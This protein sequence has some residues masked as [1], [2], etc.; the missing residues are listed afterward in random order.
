MRHRISPCLTRDRG[1][2]QGEIGL[3]TKL[4]W[5]HYFVLLYILYTTFNIFPFMSLFSFCYSD[6]V[7]GF[8]EVT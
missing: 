3:F 7:E 6:S 8:V 1:V 2:R 5:T 4:Y